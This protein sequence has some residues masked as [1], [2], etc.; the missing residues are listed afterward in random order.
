MPGKSFHVLLT[1]AHL[2]P[3]LPPQVSGKSFHVL[4]T[5]YDFLMGKADRPRLAKLMWRYLIVVSKRRGGGGPSGPGQG[6]LGQGRV[7]QAR[8][9]QAWAWQCMAGQVAMSGM[10]RGWPGYA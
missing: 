5:T 10:Q 6:R 7:G 9:G 8:P 1:T 3:P 4:L 2:P